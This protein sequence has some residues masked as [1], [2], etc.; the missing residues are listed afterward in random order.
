MAKHSENQDDHI[1]N[2]IDTISRYIEVQI[3]QSFELCVDTTP[4]AVQ[5]IVGF[6]YRTVTNG[7]T[8]VFVAVQSDITKR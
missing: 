4:E 6:Q 3:G 1:A 7:N 8:T 2:T 5:E